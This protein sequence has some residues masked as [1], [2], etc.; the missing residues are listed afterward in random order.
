MLWITLW[1]IL[2]ALIPIAGPVLA[3]VAGFRYAMAFM[4]QVDNPALP[5][6]DCL[7]RSKFLMKG[8]KG[9]LFLLSLSFIGWYLL[10]SVPGAILS[11]IAVNITVNS[12][13]L[14]IVNLIGTFVSAFV[15]AYVLT[16]Y[17]AFYDMLIGRIYGESY[18]PGQF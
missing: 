6:R 10:A 12:F 3:I 17:M 14:L 8:N 1:V 4:V 11:A 15:V 18:T 13:V 16:A 7:N 2:W 9:K 5:I